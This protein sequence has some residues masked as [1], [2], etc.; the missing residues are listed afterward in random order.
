MTVGPS[1]PGRLTSPVVPSAPSPVAGL[2]T[3]TAAELASGLSSGRFRAVD[4]VAGYRRRIDQLDGVFGAIRGIVEDCAEQAAES[5]RRRERE[6]PRSPLEGVPVVV[7]D[8]IDVAGMPTTAGALALEHSVPDNDAPLVS[9]LR[10]AGAVIFAKANLSELANFLTEDMP[11]GYSSLGGQVLNPYDLALT[12]SGSSSGS[13]AAVA[14]GL[15][16]LAVGTETDGSI[17][18]P[19]AHQSLVGLKPTVGLVSRTG[20]VPIAPSQDTAGPMTATVRDAAMLLAALAGE[21]PEDPATAGA[22]A[23]ASAIGDLVLDGAGLRGARLGVVRDVGEGE[24]KESRQACCDAAMRALE[25]AGAA[26]TDVTMPEGSADDELAVLHFEFA[27]AFDRYLGRLGATAPVRSMAELA[28][29]N[30]AHGEVALKF[31]QVH[32]ERA[33]AIDHRGEHEA[34]ATTRERD[35]SAASGALES[36]LGEELEA[37]VFPGLGGTG[38][39][40][41]AGWPSLVVPAGYLAANRRPTGLLFVGRPWTEARLLSLGHAFEQA[42]PVRRPPWEINPAA[43]R[44]FGPPV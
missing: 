17:T 42:H 36:A 28:D 16:P 19:C 9:R 8:N 43:F 12:P 14:L 13:A 7:K 11:S 39:A 10:R 23:V 38:W 29:W 26:L 5:D 30:R 24:H 37:I 22:Q 32:V 35:R 1:R 25:R 20:I 41:R 21:D 18:S 4:L 44:R 6:G 34:Y 31:G 3:A 40:A 27:P 33:L 15:A 2:A